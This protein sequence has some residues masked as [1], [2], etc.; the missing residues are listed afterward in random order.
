[1]EFVHEVV[2]RLRERGWRPYQVDIT[3]LAEEPRIGKYRPA[4]VDAMS[5]ALQVAAENVNI[6]A[7]TSEGMGF[8]GRREGI[9]CWAVAS[10]V[11]L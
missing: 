8:V 2:T 3:L 11:P 10:I 7:T 9:A 5:A 6:K 1:M 4:M